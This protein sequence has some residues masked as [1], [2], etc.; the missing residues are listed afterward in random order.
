MNFGNRAD[1][2]RH[3]WEPIFIQIFEEVYS[4]RSN[5]NLLMIVMFGK[6]IFKTNFILYCRQ[7]IST[8]KMIYDAFYFLICDCN[9]RSLNTG[10][11]APEMFFSTKKRNNFWLLW[12]NYF[13]FQPYCCSRHWSELIYCPMMSFAIQISLSQVS[14]KRQVQIL[15]YTTVTF[16]RF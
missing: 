13:H 6:K 4:N 11:I 16:R 15:W 1:S 8:V 5:K 9:T 12:R 10:L 7:F 2:T 14:Q 3:Y